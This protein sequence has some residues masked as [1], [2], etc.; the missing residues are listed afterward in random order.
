MARS[1]FLIRVALLM[2]AAWLSIASVSAQSITTGKVV[3][4]VSDASGAMVPK[5]QVQLV[6]TDTNAALTAT[7]DDSGGYVFTNLPPG[8][9]KLTVTMAGFRTATIPSFAV[10]VD[11]TANLPVKLEV[12]GTGDVVEVTA[13]ATAQLQTTDAQIGNTVSTENILRLPTL[14]RNATELMNLQPG[15]VAGGAGLVMRVSGAID[16]QNTVTLD[17]IDITQNL[18]A[19][20][21]SVPTPADSIE[22]FTENVSNPS[23]T[24]TRASGGQV[25][26]IGRHGS[27]AFHGALYEF[28]QNND[29][30]TNTWDNNRAG[31][32]KAII[33]DNRYGGRLGGPILKNKTFFF[34]NY[35][36]RRFDSVAQVTRTVPTAL[37]RQG[38]VQ[39]TGPG[40]VE[41]FNLK[42][43][44]VCNAPA[45][46][47][48][49]T[50][51]D[52]RGL[53]LN[54]SVAAQWADMPLPN[55][56]GGDGLNTGSYFANLPT[57]IQTDYGVLRL[58]HMINSKVTLN[59]AL[60][61]FRSDQVA[62][63]DISILNGKPASAETTPQRAIVPSLSATWQISPT[64]FN[65]ARIGWVRDTSQTNAT[66][67]TKAAGILNIPGSQTSAGPV[68]LAI[69]S[70]VSSFID[71]P[72]DL[73][74][75]RARFQAAW[76][77]NG[78]L[79]DDLTKVL[80]K[81]ELRFGVQI[82]KIDFTHAR[83]DKVVGS[84]TSLVALID[85]DQLNLSIPAVNQPAVCSGS[86]TGNCIPSNQLTNWDRYYASALGLVDNVGILAVR[87]SNL[88]PQ[89][90]GTFLRDVTNQYATY[91]YLQDSFRIKPSLTLYYGLSYG[92]QTAPTE[93]NNLQT[94]MINAATGS[95]ITGPAYLQQKEQAAQAGNIYNPTF[96]FET[97]GA[98]KR[99]VYNT[100][101][102]DVAPRIA[103]AW[104][105]SVASG[106][107]NSLLGEKKTVIRGGFAMVYDRSNTVQSVEIPMLGI[108]FDQN[109]AVNAPA[110]NATGAGGPGCNAS[111]SVLAN[112]GLAAFRVGT[113]GTLPLPVASAATS[114]IIP[115]VGAE[116]LSFQVDP[117][118]KTGRSYNF[119]LSVQRQL[120]GHMILEVAFLS[121][122]ARDLPQAVNVNSAPYMFKDPQ[123][124]QTFAQAYDLVA[125]AL[126]S[127]QSAPTEPFFENQ[128]P[129][130]ATA[131]GTA[132]A[133]AYIVG[134]NKANITGGSVG[135][136]FAN[137]DTYRRALG[138]PAYDS[139]QA[140]VEF[141]RTYIGYS[142]YNAGI[143]TL[144]KRM[145]HG[146]SIT[147]NY[148]F[149]KAL[150]DGL[151]N[152]N[153][154]GFYSNS[155]NPGVQ[156]GPSSYDRR[157]VVNAYYQYDLPAGAGHRFHTGN[158][159][160]KIIGGW[161]TSGVVSAWTGLP[162]K[163]SEGSQVW[164]GGN[165]SIGAT[166]YMV[167]T[168]PLPS[169]G[170]NH[171]VSNTTT[172]SN[173]ITTG[174]VG[175]NVGGASGTNLDIFSNPGAAYCDFNYVQLSSTGRTGSGDPMRGLSFWN[176][177]MRA[178]KDTR[179]GEGKV[180]LG[181]SADFFNI[182]NHEN[183]A[184]PSTSFTSPATFGVITATYTP[185]N[186]TNAGRWIE[187]G[188]RLDF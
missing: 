177:D 8:P 54:P 138:L 79:G 166:E 69:G 181:F 171:N 94:I 65:V 93:Q 3:G 137:L 77:Q 139:D 130:L 19:T 60:T 178:G 162:L 39:F 143:V 149:S 84:I 70:G 155:F 114:P 108:G 163:V 2:C 118:T 78:Q 86:I 117:N 61:Y 131:K 106:F 168:G 81:H 154:A 16:D 18:V 134:A 119:D 126:R 152:Q 112:P 23:A 144:S 57:P 29:L 89:P 101:Y 63:G 38:I 45:G 188:L 51:C 123:S 91:F 41:Q 55:L 164:G 56:A 13:A 88:Q 83:A 111:G 97:V 103:L 116:V 180:K 43:A 183:F 24:M 147:G 15:V 59:A 151:S 20:G 120:P 75:Q 158:F 37:L 85:G 26:L 31:L 169:T 159:V 9:Y 148:T 50:P 179:I 172:C 33:H 47:T 82:N 182:F 142:N 121:R 125:D 133:T 160:D 184:N 36:A 30:N 98:A 58:D 17:G 186:R 157:S 136:L 127:G 64:L 6:N 135:T 146:F 42:T 22:E 109:I 21:T 46:G 76:Q 53:G 35:E 99:P 140:G 14:Q 122:E 5:A 72:I 113:D 52:P 170:V 71:S 92:F 67:P 104:N 66:S 49:S 7:T 87:N 141:I 44:S 28:L 145:S 80:G 150:D 156:Y 11:K 173:S 185:P 96:G 32:A 73:D 10:E 4:N 1:L 25:T 90:F 40:G 176:F 68:A 48:G 27:N 100:D 102:G 128:F 132:T 12:G 175:A 187:M 165:S 129:G 62:S 95:L 161:Y 107:M 174:T 105:P 74:T 167:P 124:G 153:N 115:G 34:A 110:C